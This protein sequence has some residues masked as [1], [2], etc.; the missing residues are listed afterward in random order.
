MS[1]NNPG[2]YTGDFLEYI[3]VA[4]LD[5]RLVPVWSD[6]SETADTNAATADD[7]DYFVDRL[8]VTGGVCNTPPTVDAGG[9]YTTSEGT[10]VTVSATGSDANGDTI[11]YAWD[12]DNNGTFETPGQSVTFDNVGQDG[13]FT[14]AVR[15][16]DGRPGG[17]ATDTATVTVT[18]VAPTVTIGNNGPVSENTAVTVSGV[19]SDAGFQETP[20]TATI[21]WGDG[22]GTQPL[23]GTV[24]SDRPFKT[25][26]YSVTHTYG[27]DG[28]FTVSVCA[29]DDDTT[30][31]CNSTSVT[32]TNTLPTA[33]IDETGTV[34]VNGVPTF[35]A[36]AGV[37]VPFEADSFDPGSDDR[38]TTWDWGDGAPSPDS[39]ELSLNDV[40]FN[41]D[42]DPSPTIN[43]RTVTD[44]E[45]HAFGDACFYTV[46]FGAADD[47]GGSASDTVKVIIAG[48][49]SSPR[50]AGYWQTQYRPRPTAFTEARRQCYLAIAG[51]M[52]NVFNEVRNAGT[53]PAAFDVLKV[54]QKTE[55][56]IEQLDRQTPDRLA[57]LRQ[58]RLRP[59]RAR[60]HRWKRQ[61]G[62]AV[63]DGDGDRR[64]DSPQPGV[65]RR[66]TARPARHPSAHQ[67][68][69]A[70]SVEGRL[71]RPST[72]RSA[73]R[74]GLIDELRL[75]RHP[76][77]RSRVA[78]V[79][80]IIAVQ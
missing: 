30:G 69:L 64:G 33:V 56:A 77:S 9:P 58:R 38:T 26:T 10:N 1:A 78:C 43:P 51:F 12:L 57:E 22:S 49:E 71:W 48:N 54:S 61:R 74:A 7:N 59:H 76:A 36:H 52:S 37:T 2:S 18:N 6:N 20:L 28:T 68:E 60:R 14:I 29:A 40:L 15:A 73:W 35:V 55:T 70:R 16:D 39:T 23:A 5:C 63:R 46:T 80:L 79:V 62:H 32:V 8:I 44:D 34:L 75:L 11:T 19:V 17:T 27:D 42:P 21:D 45:P 47:D 72:P 41:P 67:Q 25:I 65:D 53:V 66:A 50:D 24:E 13:S 3:G 31:N 4:A